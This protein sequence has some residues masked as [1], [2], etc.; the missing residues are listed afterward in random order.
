MIPTAMTDRTQPETMPPS[1]AWQRASE[2]MHAYFRREPVAT[3]LAVGLTG[4]G[5][6]QA[7]VSFDSSVLVVALAIVLATVLAFRAE[8]SV[9][10]IAHPGCRWEQPL[11]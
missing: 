2:V 3:V 5:L 1:L 9:P 11:P 6:F 8:S 7:L 10:V 4:L